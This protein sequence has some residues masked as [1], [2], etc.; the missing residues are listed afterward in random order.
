MFRNDKETPEVFFSPPIEGGNVLCEQ[1]EMFLIGHEDST[2]LPGL[3]RGYLEN[4]LLDFVEGEL[5]AF[6]IRRIA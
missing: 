5:I 4:N 1:V 3:S 6:P 2:P